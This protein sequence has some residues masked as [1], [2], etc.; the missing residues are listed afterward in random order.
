M[1]NLTIGAN[2]LITYD[3]G[4]I[5]RRNAYTNHDVIFSFQLGYKFF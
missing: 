2:L 4:A 1:S 3:N 5:A